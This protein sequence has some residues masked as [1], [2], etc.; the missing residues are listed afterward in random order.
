ML[1]PG[2]GNGARDGLADVAYAIDHGTFR[3]PDLYDLDRHLRYIDL[4]APYADRCLFVTAPDVLGDPIGTWEPARPVLAAIRQRGF[5][6][7]L[8]AQDGIDWRTLDWPAVDCVFVGG[9]TEWKLSEAAYAVA[10][11]AHQRGKWVHLGRVN[12]YRR[13]RAGRVSL[14][15]SAD[16]TFLAFGRDRNLPQ[17]LRWLDDINAQSPLLRASLLPGRATLHPV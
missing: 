14:Y 17:L 1:N 6:A 8:V 5:P 2:G 11:E 3:R 9:S 16:G 13:L 15:D 12:S 7:A 10:A 4:H